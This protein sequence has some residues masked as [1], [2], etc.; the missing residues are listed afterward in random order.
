MLQEI[1][2]PFDKTYKQLQPNKNDFVL[3]F[4]NR[5]FLAKKEKGITRFPTV[6]EVKKDVMYVFSVDEKKYFLCQEEIQLEGYEYFFVSELKFHAPQETSFIVMN[7]Y[8]I[9]DWLGKNKYCGRC[10]NQMKLDS[11]ELMVRC[12]CGNTVYPRINPAVNIAIVNGNK[13]LMAKHIRHKNAPYSLLAGF[14]EYGETL[15][16]TVQREVMEEVGLKVK[17]IQYFDSQPWGVVGNIQI[18]YFCELDGSDEITI[19]KDELSEAKWFEREDVPETISTYSITGT[20][21]HE[22]KYNSKA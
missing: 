13:L 19:Q 18:G 5:E 20:M 22:F 14:V 21:I 17:N 8:H 7:G 6:E 1:H 12:N 10:G 9:W 4:R 15:E 3:V 11:K 16:Q 2:K